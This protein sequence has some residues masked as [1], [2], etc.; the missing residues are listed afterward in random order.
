MYLKYDK[1]I[2]PKPYIK[3]EYLVSIIFRAFSNNCKMYC[4]F[5][6]WT[7]VS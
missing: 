2:R 3:M 5:L 1:E 4:M 6:N 7:S